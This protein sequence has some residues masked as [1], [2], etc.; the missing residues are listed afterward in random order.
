MVQYDAVV[1]G[2][3]QA[4][5]SVAFSYAAQGKRVAVVE[6]AQ[7]GG[8][9][10]NHG[11]RPT[12]ALRASATV[13]H[14]ARRAAEFGVHVGEVR[15]DFGQ[16]IGRVHTLIDGMRAGL[17]HAL[18]SADNLDYVEGR[19]TLVG[20]PEGRA[21]RVLVTDAEGGEQELT[22]PEVHLNVGT[23]AAIPSIDG[24]EDVAYL[25]ETELLNLTELPAHLVI[26]GGG[27]IGLEF[28]Q[29]FRRFG[30]EVT[31]V[32]GG[33]IAAREDPDVQQILTDLFT[34]EGVTIVAGRPSHVRQEGDGI[35]LEVPEVGTITGSHLL[36]ATG[37]RSNVDLL[38]PD[39]GL[40]TD[41]RGFVITD[42]RYAT[43]VPGVWALGDVNGRG[44]FTHTSYQDGDIYLHPPRT[45]AGR[46]TTYAMFTDPPLGRVG[47][48]LQ[49]A[50][51]SGRNVLKGE[52]PMSSVSRA[53]LESEETGVMRVLVDADTEEF[54]GATIL[55]LQADD[56]VQVIGVAMQAGVRYP[57]VRD[58]LPIHPT[59]SEFF[60]TILGSLEPLA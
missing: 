27:Y 13:A 32:A 1:I 38:G 29:M 11:C 4:G 36:V 43:S 25:T 59:V 45:V 3:G 12:K 23:R 30:S 54:L 39:S 31:I 22:A 58:A 47:M 6:M 26:V 60:P 46:V 55:G 20:D 24:L 57:V 9:C 51:D 48:S 10:L 21:H 33:G 34:S 18:D 49:D 8:T 35:A 15:V 56:V 16:A 7:P 17:Q 37:R 52:V 44:A 19:A 42:D 2:A 50:R 41:E 53:R 40:E 28:G 5:P 14:S